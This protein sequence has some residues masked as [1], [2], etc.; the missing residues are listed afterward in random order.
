M[1]KDIYLRKPFILINILKRLMN[2]DM[3]N[4]NKGGGGGGTTTNVIA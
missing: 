4:K 3:G 1:F 2:R